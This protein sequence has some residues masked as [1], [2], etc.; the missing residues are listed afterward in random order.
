MPGARAREPSSASRSA[1]RDGRSPRAL[2]DRAVC[3]GPARGDRQLP[4]AGDDRRTRPRRPAA[5]RSTPAT[6]SCPRARGW[7]SCRASRGSRSSGRRPEVIELAGDKLAR[8]RPRRRR[9]ALPIVPGAR[10][11]TSSPRTRSRP[12]VASRCCSRPR[13]AAVGAGSSSRR[14]EAS[15]D[16]VFGVAVAEAA[17]R[18]ATRA[19]TS[20]A[21]SPPRATSRCRS[22]PTPTAP[23]STSASATAR[24]SAATRRSSRRRPRRRSTPDAARGA[25]RRRRRVRAPRSATQPRH[26]RVHGRRARPA[27]TSSSR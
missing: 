20:S 13:A 6:A 16:A 5:T 14:D 21:S 19:S 8:A 11:R 9:P 24:S 15:L 25:D 18:S 26:R 3:I 1:D 12:T 4:A 2:A 22:P 17:R 27:S 23:W 7:R 10:S